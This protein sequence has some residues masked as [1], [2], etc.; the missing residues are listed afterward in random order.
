MEREREMERGGEENPD[1]KSSRL[2]ALRAESPPRD[3]CEQL[4]DGRDLDRHQTGALQV[5][6]SLLG[7]MEEDLL[8]RRDGQEERY[9]RR[10]RHNGADR[11]IESLKYVFR[12]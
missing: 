3:Q 8:G 11:K 2:R 7:T 9:H 6:H 12:K 5:N 4:K 1:L 10:R